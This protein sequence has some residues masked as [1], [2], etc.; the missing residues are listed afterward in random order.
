MLGYVSQPLQGERPLLPGHPS[1]AFGVPP[2]DP[3]A[4]YALAPAGG[5]AARPCEGRT[6]LFGRNRPE[7]HVCVGE[8]DRHVSR[9]HGSVT[10]RGD[11]WWV[12]STGRQPL[13]LPGDRLLF[14]DDDPVPLADGYTPLFVRGS[15][16]REHLLELFVLGPDGE[17]PVP[18]PGDPTQP[19]RVWRLTDE[20]RLA[21]IVLAQRYLLHEAHPQPL[22]W[23]QAAEHLRELRPGERWTHKRVEHLIVAVRA[24][25][26][27]GGVRGL[28]REEVGEPV[29]NAL[30]HNLI[31]ELMESTTVVPPDLD[32][33]SLPDEPDEP[34]EPGG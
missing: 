6:I 11:R 31:R 5:F 23:R 28:T 14:P 20:E 3:G 29:G 21:L 18:R 27:K 16:G 4:L 34:G 30:N 26:S 2:A 25:L 17:P 19:P 24:R 1:L 8:S 22:S 13:R 32:L 12:R 9:R 7:V 15:R 33:I 10:R